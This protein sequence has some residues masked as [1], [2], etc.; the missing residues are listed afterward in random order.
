MKR[1]SEHSLCPGSQCRNRPSV[2]TLTLSDEW[3][4]TVARVRPTLL[5]VALLAGVSVGTVSNVLTK[6]RYARPEAVHRVEAAVAELGYR[7]NRVAQALINGQTRTIGMILPNLVSPYHVDLLH[8][9]EEVLSDAGYAVLFGNS[10]NDPIKEERCI[11]ALRDRLVDGLV[12]AIATDTGADKLRALS[13]EVPIVMINRLVPGWDGDTV[14]SDTDTGMELAVGHLVDLGHSRIALVN[15]DPRIQTARVRRCAFEAAMQRRGL[16]ACSITEDRFSV[17]SGRA[18]TESI[19]RSANP[20][21]AICAGNDV[22]ALG[23]LE[24]IRNAG[25]R[26]P[27]DLSVVGYND[28][29]YT[30]YTSPSLTTIHVPTRAMGFEAARLILG[31]L[32]RPEGPARHIVMP[33]T[34]V[35]RQSTTVPRSGGLPLLG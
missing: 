31:R 35:V 16:K 7:P 11:D 2:R 3:K 33:T 17:E 8:A 19:L 23:V 4:S 30:R 12:T 29:G 26:V 22:I 1:F 15:G 6:S 24:A 25:L 34:L 5:D 28:V 20:P 13:E 10:Q 27:D 18:Q 14:T 21:T 9:V 32:E